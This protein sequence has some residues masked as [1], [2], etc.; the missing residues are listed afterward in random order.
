MESSYPKIVFVA[1]GR[2]KNQDHGLGD[3]FLKRYCEESLKKAT[4]L[5]KKKISKEDVDDIQQGDIII[6]ISAIR[7]M[8]GNIFIFESC[9]PTRI[10][11][12]QSAYLPENLIFDL[13]K[14]YG[15]TPESFHLKIQGYHWRPKPGISTAAKKNL[16]ITLNA[17]PKILDNILNKKT[18]S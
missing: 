10:K 5:I 12:S 11:K 3:E 4:C 7:D 6:F 9:I 1:I 2:K 15:K 8:P 17:F 16:N 13:R 14:I 18:V